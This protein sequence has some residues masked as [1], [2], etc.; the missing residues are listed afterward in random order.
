MSIK[1]F[2]ANQTNTITNAF[3]ANLQT[4]MTGSNNGESDTCEIF[5]IFGQASSGSYELARTLVQFPIN[6]IVAQRASGSLP[7]SG[8]VSFFLKMTNAEHSETLPRQF[9]LMVLPVSQTW[10]AGR[11]LDLDEGTDLTKDVYGSNWIRARSNVSWTNQG[12][13]F[14]SGSGFNAVNFSQFFDRGHED[15][16]ID[17]SHLVERWIAGTISNNGVVVMLSGTTESGSTSIYTKRFFAKGTEFFYARPTIEARWDASRK[18]NRG[19]FTLS[20]TLRTTADNRKSLFLYNY[21]G[22]QLQDIPNITSGNPIF[23]SLHTSASSGSRITT[24]PVNITGSW[25]ATGIY[26][27]SFELST[28]ASIV[29]D[30]WFSGSVYYFTGSF[31]PLAFDASQNILQSRK[32][33]N[34][35]TNLKQVYFNNEK[36]RFRV[37]SRLKN[38]N[39]SIYTTAQSSPELNI[40]EDA[41]F[42]IVRIA[43]DFDVISY[44]TGSTNHTKLS[45]DKDG[46]YF[47]LDT[48]L[49][50]PGYSYGIRILFYLDGN[51]EEQSEI[52]K[53]RVRSV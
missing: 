21:V 5:S 15:L 22:N 26:S 39:F 45:Y 9:S 27:A 20:S 3:V 24:S 52:F 2:Y 13:D 12:G 4:R 42:K 23:V 31:E 14:L 34:S 43:D 32:Y 49:L 33:V 36:A 16:E 41:F 7:A 50:E 38:R 8:S 17:I 10:E 18:D 25:I 35:I 53:F 1:R 44:G 51:Y 48:N 6:Q 28:T 11:G 30:R 40:V 19:N 29:Y 46:G 37:F 47:D